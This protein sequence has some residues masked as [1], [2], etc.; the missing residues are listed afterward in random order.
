M[1]TYIIG[2]RLF[3]RQSAA[4]IA[5][6]MITLNP[7]NIYM[8]HMAKVDTALTFFVLLLFYFS[9]R[10][11]E[12]GRVRDM[13]LA[14][15]SAGLAM[16][17]KYDLIALLPPLIATYFYA[18]HHRGKSSGRMLLFLIMAFL[19]FF[20]ASPYTM[21]DLHSF[22][23]DI[24]SESA[25]QGLSLS[26]LGWVHSRFVYQVLVQLPFCLSISVYL[27]FMTGLFR[28]KTFMNNETFILFLSY[29]LSYFVFSTFISAS[30]SQIIFSHLYLTIVPF[31]IIL[32]SYAAVYFISKIK[33]I[34]LKYIIVG[35]LLV[36]VII[37]SSNF[38]DIFSPYKKSGKW[39]ESLSPSLVVRVA[40]VS[41]FNL[42]LG[43][44]FELEGI[45][46]SPLML[47]QIAA[48]NPQVML[49]SEGWY[50][51]YF[52]KRESYYGEPID[53]I[54]SNIGYRMIK[55]FK[56]SSVYVDLYEHID[57]AIDIGTI[58]IFAE[59]PE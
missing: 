56:P 39:M 31:I 43:G 40:Y 22:L 3:K 21:L 19:F 1:M 52:Y 53:I 58:R 26:T 48:F 35:I 10:I 41:P 7:L 12:N 16:G 50:K 29:P 38:K 34:F 6:L 23:V 32:S 14:G 13:V 59:R 30:I 55:Q 9:L 15:I 49:V 36:D 57:S 42:Y 51:T 20:L 5:A 28:F 37:A 24:S 33:I 2:Q 27:L 54:L 17:T 44:N 8:S 4:L 46:P 18:R 47:K 45:Q 11:Q 25:Q